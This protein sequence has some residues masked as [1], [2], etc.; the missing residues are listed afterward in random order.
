MGQQLRKRA[1]RKRRKN[2]LARKKQAAKAAA[3]QKS[4]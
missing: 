2:W 4:A 3:P 1:K